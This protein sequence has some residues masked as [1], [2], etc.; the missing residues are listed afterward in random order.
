ME[1]FTDEQIGDLKE[2]FY[3]FDKT[4]S[5]NIYHWDLNTQTL[6]N[7]TMQ[8]WYRITYSFSMCYNFFAT[9]EQ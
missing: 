6:D 3:I 9:K 8:A 4:R 5:G 1:Y 2:I 7:Y